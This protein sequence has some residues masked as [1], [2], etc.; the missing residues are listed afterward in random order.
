M[1]SARMEGSRCC[2]TPRVSPP[3][4]L[5]AVFNVSGFEL[6]FLLVLGLIVLGPEKLPEVIRKVTRLYAELRKVANGIQTD[7]RE[8]FRDPLNDLRE[9]ANTIRNDFG[10]IDTEPS[11]PMRPERAE[12]PPAD[13]TQTGN[14][15]DGS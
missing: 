1:G 12:L 11:P 8:A 4:R 9:T 13:D 5:T 14:P 3:R 2:T 10:K 15:T 6:L 7:M